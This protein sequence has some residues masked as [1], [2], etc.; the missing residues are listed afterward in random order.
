MKKT[1]SFLLIG[2]ILFSFSCAAKK[3]TAAKSKMPSMALL[4]KDTVNSFDKL[5]KESSKKNGLFTTYYNSKTNKLYFEIADS[6]FA[7]L[8]MLA[9]RVSS[10]S[11]TQDYV[12]GQLATNPLMIRFSKDG[13]NVYMHKVQYMNV[14]DKDDAIASAFRN[15]FTDPVLKGFKIEAQK[16][17]SVLIDV[18]AFFGGNE[19]SISPIKPENPLAKLLG[20]SN[21][22]KGTFEPDASSITGVKTFP[23]N[24]EVLSMLTF[25][26]MPLNEP[27]TVNVQRSLFLLP[28]SPMKPR[29]DDSRV[30][31]FSTDKNLY[32]SEKSK[33][34]EFAYIHRWRLEPKPEDRDKYLRGELVEPYKPLVFYV[35]S[36]FP[37]KWR[38]IVKQGIEDW[39][40]AFVGAGFKNV[41][42]AKD[43][44]KNNPDFDPDDMR[45][46][47]VRYAVSP[48]ANA[49]GPSYVDPRTGE[50]LA[51]NVIWYHNVISLVHNWRFVQTA[52]VDA[53]V[54]KLEFDEDV[55]RESL[56]YVSSHEIGH[57]LGLMHNMGASYSFPVDS[58]RSPSFTQ[59]YG[60]T[61]SIMDYA[62]N[63]FVAQPGDLE[64][65][66][67]LTPPLLGVYDKY[68]IEWGYKLIPNTKTPQEEREI[69][70][71]WIE[72]KKNDPMFAY[73]AQQFFATVDPTAQ[74]ED[75]GNDHIKSGNLAI[76]NLKIIMENFGKW[77][78]DKEDDYK[79]VTKLYEGILSQYT[80]HLRHVMP[81]IGGVE[82]REVRQGDKGAAQT[83]VPKKA[84]KQAIVWLVN[85]ART[86]NQWLTPTDFTAKIGFDAS[87]NDRLLLSVIGCL[88][89]G[90]ALYRVGE[91]EKIDAVN[92]Y[93]LR[94]Y[95]D[96]VVN[97]VFKPTYENK[98]L[99]RDDIA[100]QTAAVNA[101]ITLSGLKPKQASAGAASS[102]DFEAVMSADDNIQWCSVKDDCCTHHHADEE[103]VSLIRI[104]F[105]MS[106]LPSSVLAPMMTARLKQVK[107][108]YAQR[109]N[110]GDKNSRDYYEYQLLQI[111]NILKGK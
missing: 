11:N 34:E 71:K 92:N 72:D 10:I 83:Y 14:V 5:V 47:C 3:Q 106:A 39:N 81:Y 36:A 27:Y 111:D 96:D 37:A 22:I 94:G 40:E 110:T 50:I 93:T 17:G 28:D 44:P 98:A 46:S 68:A 69:L 107:D 79:D 4:P 2:L 41:V 82:F 35:D 99:T 103:K 109:R 42:K 38:S 105:G 86:Y 88:F 29:L 102:D 9:N 19:R 78:Y 95:M 75:L 25:N 89:N 74:T 21:S 26:T 85:Q 80:R 100:L 58:L 7:H 8:Y 90:S 1:T 77:V 97:E 16:G 61:P 45:Y 104:N 6:A 18:T 63:N 76:S 101:M 87:R 64:K 67:R 53:R 59:K 12:A 62:R 32:T 31:F 13:K 15:N 84:Q 91:G 20:G 108:L 70:S 43:Y 57:T 49:M 24:I 54:R 48:I 60:T 56:R 66:V 51:A 33:I 30:G 23:R 55:M 73:G 65:G 52:A